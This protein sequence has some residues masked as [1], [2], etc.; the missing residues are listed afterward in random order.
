MARLGHVRAIQRSSWSNAGSK[1]SLEREKNRCNSRR[2]T[3]RRAT[4]GNRHV[5]F[6][7]RT[8]ASA[9]GRPPP[10]PRR[11]TTACLPS[12]KTEWRRRDQ[13]IERPRWKTKSTKL[14]GAH[15][16]QASFIVV[17]GWKSSNSSLHFRS[18]E[19]YFS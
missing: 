10:P 3:F 9:S 12:F 17:G 2:M 1:F 7:R 16:N 4:A 5:R 8:E 13:K 14:S 15:Q 19:K 6:E 18:R 11:P